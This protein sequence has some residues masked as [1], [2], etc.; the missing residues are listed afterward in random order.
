M[1]ESITLNMSNLSD[2]DYAALIAL[3]VKSQAKT[4]KLTG[5]VL[6]V[7]DI[8]DD[9][10]LTCD[11]FPSQRLAV[12]YIETYAKTLIDLGLA[13]HTKEC[14]EKYLATLKLQQKLRIACAESW[15]DVEIDWSYG[16][17]QCKYIIAYHNNTYRTDWSAGI[18]FGLS[19]FKTKEDCKKFIDENVADLHLLFEQN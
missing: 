8:R 6:R 12:N 18:N 9:Y 17:G 10:W 14:A 1:N 4:K 19:V 13:F 3:V 5:R 2:E 11:D 7:E 16:N 15:G